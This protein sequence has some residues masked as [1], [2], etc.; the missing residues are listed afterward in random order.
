MK[1]LISALTVLVLSLFC[2]AGEKEPIV[3]LKMGDGTT[4]KGQILSKSTTELVVQTEFG[5]LRVPVQ[6]LTD[7]SRR[8]LFPTT[9][10]ASLTERMLELESKVKALEVEN[11]MLRKQLA[12]AKAGT[13]TTP[14]SKAE[15]GTKQAPEK[16]KSLSTSE[17]AGL[18]F[19]LSS[20]GKRHN[21]RC[22]FFGAGKPCDATAGVAC[23]VCGG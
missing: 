23:K 19:S 21:S 1:I 14:S 17:T 2:L 8:N 5:T 11:Q 15:T 9:D 10:P 20:T 16:V 6:K 3:D 13:I 4:V 7:E 22:R 18:T 12:E